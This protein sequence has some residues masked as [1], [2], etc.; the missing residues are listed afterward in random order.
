MGADAQGRS[1]FC[2]CIQSL[3]NILSSVPD[4]RFRQQL[5]NDVLLVVGLFEASAKFELLRTLIERCPF[6]SVAS[7]LLKQVKTEVR[8]CLLCACEWVSGDADRISG[9]GT[10][11]RSGEHPR[12]AV[13][14]AARARVP[15]ARSAHDR[16]PAQLGFAQ[17]GRESVSVCVLPRQV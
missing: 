6:A 3:V 13:C 8:L 10:D 5:M 14:V 15:D 2:V 7:L 9:S 4:A 17:H 16:H 1:V 11:A 12:I